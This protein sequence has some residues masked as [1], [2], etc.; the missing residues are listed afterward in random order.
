MRNPCSVVVQADDE[1]ARWFRVNRVD[2]EGVEPQACTYG[3]AGR[4]ALEHVR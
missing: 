2:M 3:L 4:W 1:A